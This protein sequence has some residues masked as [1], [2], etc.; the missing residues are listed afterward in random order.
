MSNKEVRRPSSPRGRYGGAGGNLVEISTAAT[1][2]DA[3][4]A[5]RAINAKTQRHNR[6][7]RAER[8]KA[9]EKAKI[10]LPTFNLPGD[11]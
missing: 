2:D 11:D 7:V 4:R 3:V 1:E 8:K 5:S 6:D 9:A 10:K